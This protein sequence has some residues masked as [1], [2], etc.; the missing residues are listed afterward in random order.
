[1]SSTPEIVIV[2]AGPG[3]LAS[4][5]LLASSGSKVTL[6]EK[7]QQVGG[8]TASIKSNGYTFDIGPTFFM[9]PEALEN[10]F[11]RSGRS[12]AKELPMEKLDPHYR[13]AFPDGTDLLAS[14]NL[15]RMRDQIAAYSVPDAMNLEAFL[16]ESREKFAA[17]KPVLEKDYSSWR[18]LCDWNLVKSLPILKPW[19][20]VDANLR[21]FFKD[22]RTRLAFSFQTKYLGMS[23]FRCPSLFTIL[24]YLEYDFG[25]YHPIGGCAAISDS[26][27]RVAQEM[28]VNILTGV[29]ASEIEFRGRKAVAV[30]T[31]KGKLRADAVVMNADFAQAAQRMI[32]NHLRKRWDDK[33]IG[34]AKYSCSTFMLY[35][36]VA[37][38][39]DHLPHHNIRISSDYRKNLE[40]IEGGH[41]LPSDPSFYVQNASVTDPTLAPQ[42]HSALYVLVPVSHQHKNIDWNTAA[43]A[44]RKKILGMLPQLGF[45]DVER[46]ICFERMFTPD[47]WAMQ[48]RIQHGAVFNL[49][50]TY[51]Q[52]LHL[53][54]QNRFN[55]V[56]GV[57]LVGGGTH[58]GSG[59]PVIFESANIS[60]RLLC[61]DLGLPVA[62]PLTQASHSGESNRVEAGKSELL[63]AS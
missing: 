2:G 16:S 15:D 32:P 45:E 3:G 42:G 25:I 53:R 31:N 37:G 48:H 7:E 4:A 19:Q 20:S 49:A 28:G 43:P 55:D 21:R 29:D 26:M 56:E 9:Y 41:V 54:P 58:P 12:L 24:S 34:K 57:Y 39:F 14:P 61:Q 62:P 44:F 5:M 23:P 17:V 33:R 22:E 35:L 40:E 11:R 52:M 10:I 8:R 30:Q 50:H 47:D 13:L 51:D 6:I 63:F 59:L 18:A 27:A 1:M 60:T 46:R 36:G 38:N